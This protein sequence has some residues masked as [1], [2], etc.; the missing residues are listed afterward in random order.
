VHGSST[1]TDD[2]ARRWSVCPLFEARPTGDVLDGGTRSLP[3]PVLGVEPLT[4][5]HD[6]RLVAVDNVLAA[7]AGHHGVKVNNTNRSIETV[8]AT[9]T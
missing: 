5:R 8:A 7:R 1:M 6:V 3:P 4:A 9:S 2:H